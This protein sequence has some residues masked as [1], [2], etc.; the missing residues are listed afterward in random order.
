MS[1]PQLL[2]LDLDEFKIRSHLVRCRA[3]RHRLRAPASQARGI[4]PE[5][6][7]RLGIAPRRPV[8]I[9]GVPRGWTIAGQVDLLEES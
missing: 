7:A 5:C 9:T 3:C 2:V 1:Q 8:R 6:A 4:G